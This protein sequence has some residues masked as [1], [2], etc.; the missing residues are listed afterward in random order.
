MKMKLVVFLVSEYILILVFL[1]VE[2]R[3]LSIKTSKGCMEYRIANSRWNYKVL[4]V[5]H[6]VVYVECWIQCARHRFCKAINFDTKT[7]TCELLPGIWGCRGIGAEE[8]FTFVQLGDCSGRMPF[9][10]GRRNW[11]ATCL[12][13]EPHEATKSA[14]CPPGVLRAPSGPLCA[15]LTPHRGLYLPGWYQSRGPFRIVTEQ[16]TTKQCVYVGYLL[17][18]ALECPTQWQDYTVGD[19]VP[20][21]AIKV[22]SWKDGTP[23]YFVAAKFGNIWFLGYYLPSVQRSF[24]VKGTVQSLR[25]VRILTYA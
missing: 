8:G 22:S 16:G 23:L 7:G 3:S 24:I 20:L 1:F 12:S 13:W 10:I 9:D 2:S 11:S 18:V 15:A 17:R 5:I 14:I 6:S 19:P 21:Q 25:F 4:S